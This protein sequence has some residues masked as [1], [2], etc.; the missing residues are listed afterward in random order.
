VSFSQSML[1]AAVTGPWLVSAV[2]FATSMSATPGPNNAMLASSGSLWGFRRTIPHMLGIAIGFGFMLLAVAGG[3]GTVLLHHSTALEIMRWVA[4]VYLLY[5]AYR[6]ATATPAAREPD[7]DQA[8]RGRPF[9]FL[10][11]AAFQWVNPKAWII[12]LSGLATLTT[13]SSGT[14][15]QLVAMLAVTFVIV[16]CFSAALWTSLGVTAA[17]FMRTPRALRGFNLLMAA[18]LVASIAMA[19]AGIG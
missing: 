4:G 2:A 3:L 17:R 8:G 9:T 11:A 12:V 6:I 15:L 1:I 19:L 16:I 13:A 14:S 10:Q 7:S 18:L 5:L